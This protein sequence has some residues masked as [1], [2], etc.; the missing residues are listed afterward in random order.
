MIWLA[1][2]QQRLQIITSVVLVAIV[3]AVVVWVRLSVAADLASLGIPGCWTT[4]QGC[5]APGIDGLIDKYS[6]YRTLYPL[7]GLGLPAVLGMFV[8]APM[9]A[10]EI[11]RGTHVFALTQSLSRSRWWTTRAV[12]GG[13]PVVL[14]MA[15]LGL[16]NTWATQPMPGMASRILTPRFETEGLTLGAYTLLAITLGIAVGLWLRS[17][18]ATM[19]ITLALYVGVVTLLATTLR[20]HYAQPEIDV[21]AID[22]SNSP[23]AV[24][25]EGAW[26][27]QSGYLDDNGAEVSTPVDCNGTGKRVIESRTD[28]EACLR[29][30]GLTHRFYRYQPEARYWPFQVIETTIVTLLVCALLG[31]GAL[32]SRR[33]LT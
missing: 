19:A 21:I 1:W 3:S 8:G 24:S 28:T 18:V 32:A 2:R 20:Q 6:T 14:A 31:L 23:G 13:L 33:R 22:A 9:F 15:A 10:R 30:T 7:V 5:Y 27:I 12:V 25:L 4:A 11:E 17:T 16:L 29:D 26:L